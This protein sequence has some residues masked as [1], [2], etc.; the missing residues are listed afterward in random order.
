ME[1]ETLSHSAISSWSVTRILSS[2]FGAVG[3]PCTLRA[4]TGMAF[5][6]RLDR[7]RLTIFPVLL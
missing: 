2:I 3:V 6:S 5:R 1:G 4:A 7:L